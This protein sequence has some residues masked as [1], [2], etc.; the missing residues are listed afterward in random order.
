MDMWKPTEPLILTDLKC[1]YHIA[2]FSQLQNM[3]KALHEG[4]CFVAGNFL[5]VKKWEPTSSPN[6]PC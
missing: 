2:K 5:S 3:H 4:P 1:D 6:Y